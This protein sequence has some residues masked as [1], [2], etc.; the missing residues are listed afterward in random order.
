[1]GYYLQGPDPKAD[2]LLATYPYFQEVTLSEAAG[3]VMDE[4]RAVVVV[5]QNGMFDAAAF[6]FSEGEFEEFTRD[7]DPRP[8]RFLTGPRDLVEV[9]SRY[10]VVEGED[11]MV[12]LNKVLETL[13]IH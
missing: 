2:H 7:D 9:L 8:R 1:M 3:D 4:D 13:S 11:Q 5:V 6:A 12:T 10:R